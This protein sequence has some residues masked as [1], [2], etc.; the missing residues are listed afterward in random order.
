VHITR[1]V[2]LM[3]SQ[4]AGLREIRSTIDEHYRHGFV[5]PTDT[6]LPNE[7]KERP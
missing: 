1:E 3:S 5:E 4:G 7:E 2:M 6:P